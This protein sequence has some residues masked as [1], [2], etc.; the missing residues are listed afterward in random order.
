M[1]GRVLLKPIVIVWW[2]N[3]TITGQVSIIVFKFNSLRRIDRTN[4]ES[5]RKII[6]RFDFNLGLIAVT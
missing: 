5:F 3:I 2:V 1:D 4:K 6:N